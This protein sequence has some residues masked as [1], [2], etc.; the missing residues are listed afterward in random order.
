MDFVPFATRV[1]VS[2]CAR[3]DGHTNV[4]YARQSG[5]GACAENLLVIDDADLAQK[6]AANWRAHLAHSL[7]YEGT[8]AQKQA[9]SAK[10]A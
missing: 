7:P 8:A 10:G 3:T 1:S 4:L 2:H 5:L 9:G 6:Y